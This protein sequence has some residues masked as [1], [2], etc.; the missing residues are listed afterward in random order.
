MANP[1]AV[2][3][4]ISMGMG[5]NAV[6]LHSVPPNNLMRLSQKRYAGEQGNTMTANFTDHT[7]FDLET[8]LLF[9]GNAVTDRAIHYQYGYSYSLGS[10]SRLYSGFVYDY[11][12]S[13][14]GNIINIELTAVSKES[15]TMTNTGAANYSDGTDYI[16]V[17]DIV[18]KIAA[19]N[20][21]K[22]GEIEDTTQIKRSF[23]NSFLSPMEYINSDLIPFALSATTGIGF[24]SLYFTTN[25]Q[26]NTVVNFKSMLPGSISAGT[27]SYIDT[28]S[29]QVYN[30]PMSSI[31]S[32]NPTSLG[33]YLLWGGGFTETNTMTEAY[34]DTYTS[35]STQLINPTRDTNKTWLSK[36]NFSQLYVSSADREAADSAVKAAYSKA[37]SLQYNA[38][39]EM[40]GDPNRQVGET[41]EFNIILKN[42]VHYS[43]GKYLVL[44][45]EDTVDSSG[46][47]TSLSLVKNAS[48]AGSAS[49]VI[50]SPATDVITTTNSSPSTGNGFGNSSGG[51]W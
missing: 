21:W 17:S 32:W 50:S 41:L 2:Q 22:L 25:I 10:M 12:P 19:A 34:G 42:K 45:V 15:S 4:S 40:I 11:T 47:R 37:A 9:L 51:H 13:I 27:F 44:G 23:T 39:C 14:A 26:G 48:F 24:Y 30:H 38:S 28:G 33:S 1:R 29:S 3:V 49:S 46:Y 20:Q 7:A 31:L 36:N 6:F 43:S 8:K 18:K 5:D 16:R 35:V